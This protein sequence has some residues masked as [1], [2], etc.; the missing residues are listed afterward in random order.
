[1]L[2]DPG[3]SNDVKTAGRPCATA[4]V[5]TQ[6]RRPRVS[7][8][9]IARIVTSIFLQHGTPYFMRL[10]GAGLRKPKST[11]IGVDFSGVVESVGKNVTV[12]A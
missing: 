1:V 4:K 12:Q 2:F 9:A 3:K 5:E 7:S 11:G 8:E 6:L 10:M